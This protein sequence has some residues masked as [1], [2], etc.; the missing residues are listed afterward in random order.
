[1]AILNTNALLNKLLDALA[2]V[3]WSATA[4]QRT[5]PFL[6]RAIA[7]DGRSFIL[8]IYIWNCTHGGATRSLDEYRIQATGNMPVRHAGEITLLLGWHNEYDV[9]AAWDITR[10]D[11]QSSSSPSAQ[12]KREVLERAHVQAFATA[13]NQKGEIV[14]AFKP[15]FLADYAM[16]CTSLRQTGVA[17]IDYS[18]LNDVPKLT[19]TE[20]LAITNSERREIVSKIVR[21]YRASD[22]R[23]R[24]LAAYDHQCAVCGLQ[25]E[26][27]EAAH[28][29]PVSEPRSTDETKNGIALCALH[30]AAFDAK[31]ISF[32]ENYRIE[33]SETR[34]NVLGHA[35]R[36][37]GA[38]DFQRAL[39][40]MIS[41][42]ADRRDFPDE[43]YIQRGREARRWIG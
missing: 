35:K 26:L 28:I 19:D 38:A 33:I 27:V 6:I 17:A 15:E 31:L 39:R 9:F 25:L 16:S 34:L 42:P 11:G 43:R 41:L 7:A 36:D 20:V 22:F 10:H 4:V 5:K 21:R 23:R 18:L 29:E 13:K 8:H 30:H 40:P 32:D 12:I 1:M 2:G 24:V 37:S 3:G 14:V